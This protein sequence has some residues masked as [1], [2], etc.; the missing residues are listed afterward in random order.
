MEKKREKILSK[1]LY[2]HLKNLLNLK[3]INN[4]NNFS[5]K[6]YVKL[7]LPKLI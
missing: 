7:F 3:Y 5:D 4:L 6:F 2:Q 1:N